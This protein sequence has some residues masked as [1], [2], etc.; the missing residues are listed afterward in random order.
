MRHFY[1]YIVQLLTL[2]LK[3]LTVSKQSDIVL[4]CY[5]SCCTAADSCEK[6]KY[7]IEFLQY[8]L[9]VYHSDNQLTKPSFLKTIKIS[10]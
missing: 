10:K 5:F 9:R 7:F 3:L 2:R 6:K 1:T 8:L 4:P